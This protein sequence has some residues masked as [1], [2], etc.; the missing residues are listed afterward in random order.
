MVSKMTEMAVCEWCRWGFL[1]EGRG[2][3][4]VTHDRCGAILDLSRTPYGGIEATVVTKGNEGMHWEILSAAAWPDDTRE[5]ESRGAAKAQDR[6]LHAGRTALPTQNNSA[7][8]CIGAGAGPVSRQP[9]GNSDGGEPP[10]SATPSGSQP[11]R[12]LPLGGWGAW[13]VR[14]IKRAVR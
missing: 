10:A 6:T 2:P 14:W 11:M 1:V 3:S 5:E 8:V 12:R 7:R 13:I 9:M 4:R